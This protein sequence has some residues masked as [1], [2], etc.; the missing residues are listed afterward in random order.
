MDQPFHLSGVS[1]LDFIR[2]VD[3]PIGK[4]TDMSFHQ[5]DHGEQNGVS[6]WEY[7][8]RRIRVMSFFGG[9]TSPP[10]GHHDREGV[11]GRATIG[12]GDDPMEGK[13]SRGDLGHVVDVS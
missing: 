6:F 1:R 12:G 9:I 3:F 7:F 4:K 13:V 2:F 5:L 10:G 8:S 11:A